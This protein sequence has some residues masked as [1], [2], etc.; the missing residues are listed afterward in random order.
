MIASGGFLTALECRA[1]NGSNGSTF[2]DGSHGSWVSTR[3]PLTH[4]GLANSNNNIFI[5]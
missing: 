2:L 1:D 5:V 3:D 4:V